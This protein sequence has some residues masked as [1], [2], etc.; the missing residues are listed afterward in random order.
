MPPQKYMRPFALHFTEEILPEDIG[1]SDP[2][3]A[4]KEYEKSDLKKLHDASF[5]LLNSR[6]SELGGVAFGA[7]DAEQVLEN[8]LQQIDGIL[9]REMQDGNPKT[10]QDLT[11]KQ[12][13]IATID[14]PFQLLCADA[15][16]KIYDDFSVSTA[17]GLGAALMRLAI[18]NPETEMADKLNAVLKEVA[19][20]RNDNRR[21]HGQHAETLGR[22]E[23]IAAATYSISQ[24]IPESKD[25]AQRE[26]NALVANN[27]NWPDS[28]QVEAIRG[29]IA[30]LR[31]YSGYGT[32]PEEAEERHAWRIRNDAWDDQA[33]EEYQAGI[34]TM[35]AR[36]RFAERNALSTPRELEK[37]RAEM[38]AAVEEI[39]RARCGREATKT[40]NAPQKKTK[41]IRPRWGEEERRL[42]DIKIHELI[43][44]GQ[45]DRGVAREA[46]KWAKQNP[47][48]AR[49]KTPSESML[50]KWA[51]SERNIIARKRKRPY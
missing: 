4:Q 18:E 19:E 46:V 5:E 44:D 30:E 32:T 31:F 25:A 33:E 11:P 47:Q 50:Q 51:K 7:I 29:R 41:D 21:E 48:L 49:Y 12:M 40:K 39:R 42:Y 14:G 10:A 45:T 13:A 2:E 35:K 34:R 28:P 36:I 16:R 9:L 8:T 37:L 43:M 20:M 24:S 27:P 15:R 3:T 23:S 22:V 38:A 26:L 17:L 6:H 1:T